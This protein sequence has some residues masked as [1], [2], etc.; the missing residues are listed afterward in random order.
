MVK[1]GAALAKHVSVNLF[2]HVIV[3]LQGV[4]G[5]I[6]CSFE[7]KPGVM[8]HRRG[9][10]V[11][12]ACRVKL[13]S[14]AEP[15]PSPWSRWRTSTTAP[16]AF[17][18]SWSTIRSTGE[19]AQLEKC[20]Q[21]LNCCRF[22]TDTQTPAGNTEFD[23]TCSLGA[24]GLDWPQRESRPAAYRWSYGYGPWPDPSGPTGNQTCTQQVQNRGADNDVEGDLTYKV[25][26]NSSPPPLLFDPGVVLGLE[27][28]EK[29]QS[30]P[31]GPAPCGHRMRREGG[32]V[33]PHSQ[34]QEKPQ[35]QHAGQVV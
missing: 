9:M 35:L 14:W 24:G 34:L 22:V 31:G 10:N 1:D 27:R 30:G 12:S 15:S 13:T 6:Y 16:L 18:P 20:W 17:L 33:C 4:L 29:G 8:F 28:P 11:S 32:S 7:S 3:T 5:A 25:Q 2:K 21:R 23:V 26:M 19:T